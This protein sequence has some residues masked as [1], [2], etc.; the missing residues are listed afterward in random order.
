MVLDKEERWFIVSKHCKSWDGP[1]TYNMLCSV[2][3]F[4]LLMWSIRNL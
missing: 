2:L 1:Q 3:S 4:F